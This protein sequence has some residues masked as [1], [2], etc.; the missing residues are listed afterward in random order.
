M[1]MHSNDPETILALLDGTLDESRARAVREH[2]AEC[3]QCAAELAMQQTAL[4]AL[5]GAPRAFLTAAE[6]ADLHRT[7]HRRLGLVTVAEHRPRRSRLASRVAALAGVAAVLIGV[8]AVAPHLSFLASED[9]SDVTVAFAQFEAN[10]VAPEEP[11]LG[12]DM[13]AAAGATTYASEAGGALTPEETSPSFLALQSVPDLDT[14]R[15]EVIAAGGDAA[16]ATEFLSED[17]EMAA[18]PDGGARTSSE[19]SGTCVDSGLAELPD[20]VDAFV[21]ANAMSDEGEV[22]VIAY[23]PA[24]VDDTVILSHLLPSCTIVDR[25]P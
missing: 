22:Q 15:R 13:R 18:V 11:I 8:L 7:M 4:A 10:E 24:D 6:S 9:S 1:T 25:S 14:V 3:D 19:D 20:T 23:V 12:D 2:I 21:V 16:R 17:G 5:H